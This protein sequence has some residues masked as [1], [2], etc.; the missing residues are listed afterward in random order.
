[1]KLV[2]G[3]VTERRAHCLQRRANAA[4]TSTASIGIPRGELIEA[5]TG[6][7]TMAP[8]SFHVARL[9]RLVRPHV[10]GPA[11]PEADE[12]DT[13]NESI[14]TYC[15][16]VSRMRVTPEA[17]GKDRSIGPKTAEGCQPHAGRFRIGDPRTIAACREA[18]QASA[19]C[20]SEQ[21]EHPLSGSAISACSALIVVR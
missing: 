20:R 13:S 17:S 11:Q 6:R 7:Q 5:D 12:G 9:R 1:M 21:A 14:W 4:S 8:A 2:Q 15:A 18:G 16:R 10:E 3:D 19:Q